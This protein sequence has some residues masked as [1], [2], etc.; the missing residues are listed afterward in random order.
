M[1][2]VVCSNDIPFALV[3]DHE[4]VHAMSVGRPEGQTVRSRMARYRLQSRTDVWVEHREL[5]LHILNVGLWKIASRGG[6]V[7]SEVQVER[8]RKDDINEKED[9]EVSLPTN[10]L[11][12][13]AYQVG[14]CRVELLLG[15]RRIR[16][17]VVLRALD[18]QDHVL[19]ERP[20]REVLAQLG[21]TRGQTAILMNAS[22]RLSYM[23]GLCL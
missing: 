7:L 16:S 10:H 5:Q 13:H 6:L 3:V 20:R 17:E 8:L 15:M 19:A 14:I 2:E 18:A 22:V 23:N 4:L 11:R 21:I 1:I 9:F 12:D